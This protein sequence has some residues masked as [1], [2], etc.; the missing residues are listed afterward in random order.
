MKY[1]LQKTQNCCC[2]YVFRLRKYDRVLRKSNELGW[3]KVEYVHKYFTSVLVYRTLLTSHIPY[4]ERKLIYRRD[5]HD[6]NVRYINK[7]SL[8]KFHLTAFKKSF[9]YSAVIIYNNLTDIFKSYSIH[10]FKLCLEGSY[11]INHLL[12]CSLFS[13]F[14]FFVLN[15]RTNKVKNVSVFKLKISVLPC[16]TRLDFALFFIFKY[17]YTTILQ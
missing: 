8:P 6:L 11:L 3:L 7:L 12:M 4:L 13:Y 9:T 5:M 2:R 10:K 1:R 14:V 17:L 15:S 16:K